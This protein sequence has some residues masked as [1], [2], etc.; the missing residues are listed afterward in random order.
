MMA[1]EETNPV[2]I[3]RKNI[4]RLPWKTWHYADLR[5]RVDGAWKWFEADWLKDLAYALLHNDAP[6]EPD[7][8]AE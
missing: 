4:R 3:A 5:V 6:K 8:G 1:R 7:D 2:E